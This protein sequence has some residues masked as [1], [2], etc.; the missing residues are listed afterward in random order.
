[1]T[2]KTSLYVPLVLCA[3][4]LMTL[5]FSGCKRSEKKD[6]LPPHSPE[7][8][9]KD[10][11]FMKAVAEKR[12]ALRAIV[13]ERKPLADR[14]QELVREHREDLATLQKIP[15]WT[16]LYVKVTAL[17]KKYEALRQEQLKFVGKRIS[18]SASPSD[19]GI[20]K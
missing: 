19:K 5:V 2:R 15:E 6:V 9:M 1:M 7:V 16:N 10:P 3:I 13:A 4:G 11:A 18:K 17:N 20:S 14:M 12:D 8:Y